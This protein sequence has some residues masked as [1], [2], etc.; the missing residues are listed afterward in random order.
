MS[1]FGVRDPRP[2]VL[3]MKTGVPGTNASGH[4]L[5]PKA[6]TRR[7]RITDL[8]TSQILAYFDLELENGRILKPEQACQQLQKIVDRKQLAIS[9]AIV[10]VAL[11]KSGKHYRE[12]CNPFEAENCIV[13]NVVPGRHE[14][15]INEKNYVF[16]QDN[17]FYRLVEDLALQEPITR[18]TPLWQAT[19]IL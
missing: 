2:P 12:V 13:A 17:Y 15:F 18:F 16:G 3:K 4:M 19:N 7:I 8:E 14:Y 9:V 6:N 11:I 1:F 10:Y 5:K